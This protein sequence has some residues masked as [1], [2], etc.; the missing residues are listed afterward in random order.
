MDYRPVFMAIIQT[1][2]LF[3]AGGIIP[4]FSPALGVLAQI[5]ALF[6]P[7]PLI[8]VSVRNGRWPGLVA[9]IASSACITVLGG[10]QAGAVLVLS[11]GLMAIG[12]SEGLRKN[13]TFE[14]TSLLGGL[15]PIA[16]LGSIAL[17]YL[18]KVGKNP[19]MEIDAYL[20]ESITTAAHTY[21]SMGLAEMSAMI[22]SI[23]DKV[24]YY[25]ARLL[26]AIMI[27]ISLMQAAGCLAISRAFIARRPGREPLPQQPPFA[28][29]HA[30]DSWVWGLIV[31]L[32]LIIV[33]Q[34]TA[35]LIGW[36]FAIIFTLIYL[37]QGTAILEHYLRKALLKPFLRGVISCL[38]LALPSIVFV[39]ALGIVDIWADF[40]KVRPSALHTQE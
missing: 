37:A 19:I 28:S 13:F 26:P 10:W 20:R 39:I 8:L 35:R 24:V 11:F 23:P 12:V 31:T 2:G 17:F 4:Q 30:P 14:Q 29:W 22:S 15:L 21:S 34:E 27:S 32:A 16:V 18:V 33:P 1:L 25:F 9:L 6:T 38:I 7:V 3:L 40:R 5:L 36:N